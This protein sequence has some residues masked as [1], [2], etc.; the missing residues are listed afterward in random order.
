MGFNQKGYGWCD[1]RTHL[2][3]LS[4]QEPKE[5]YG[6]YDQRIYLLIIFM[7]SLDENITYCQLCDKYKYMIQVRWPNG[8]NH[9]TKKVDMANHW[10]IK[11]TLCQWDKY[12]EATNKTAK[13]TKEKE[14]WEAF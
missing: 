5:V 2:H 3:G 8:S 1:Q 7:M 12:I 11:H 9:M 10:L 4:E 13:K 14:N 6:W